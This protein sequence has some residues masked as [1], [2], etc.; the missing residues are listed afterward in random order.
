MSNISLPSYSV[1]DFTSRSGGTD[2]ELVVRCKGKCFIV[3]L[4]ANIFKNSPT[5]LKEYLQFLKVIEEDYPVNNLTDEDFYDWIMEPFHNLL[6]SLP[7]VGGRPTLQDYFFG[8]AF[9]YTVYLDGDKRLPIESEKVQL[10]PFKGM[11]LTSEFYLDWPVFNPRQV[12]SLE[13]NPDARPSKVLVNGSLTCYLKYSYWGDNRTAERELTTYTRI[14]HSDLREDIRVPRLYGLVEDDNGL[15]LGLL[16]TY[17]DC[18]GLDMACA[19]A[20]DTPRSLRERWGRQVTYALK[21]LHQAGIVWGD[22]KPH[23]ILINR[24][25]DAWI[26]DFGGDHSRGWV[27]KEKAGTIEGDLQ[28]LTKILEYLSIDTQ[29]YETFS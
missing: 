23:N 3:A 4:H 29:V 19:V 16:L 11:R 27:D 10:A 1:V 9:H 18:E 7:S 20:P 25:Q 2:C 6:G 17:V 26:V 22:A 24:N 8:E 14:K 12:E 5:I 13:D 15:I 21:S 28:G